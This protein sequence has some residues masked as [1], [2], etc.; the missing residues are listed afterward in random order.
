MISVSTPDPDRTDAANRGRAHPNA[1]PLPARRRA[2]T[3]VMAV[4]AAPVLTLWALVVAQWDPLVSLDREIATSLYA[5][6]RPLP[7][8][9]HLTEV[10]TETFGTWSMRVVSLLAACWLLLRRWISAA[11]WAAT[12]VFLANLFGLFLK[13][14]V[15]RSRPEFADP[16]GTGVGPS[17]PSGHALMAVVGTGIVLFATLPLLRGRARPLAW[18]VAVVIVL[19]TALSRPL[20][21]VHW[22]SDIVAGVSLG[23]FTLAGTLLLWS[24]LPPIARRWDRP[25]N[26]SAVRA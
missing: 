3:V 20:L 14:T 11:A 23:V 24:F 16:I 4:A 5:F 15:D 18:G 1:T 2:L 21:A 25:A 26:T 7:E 19:S 9:A 13:L 17:F 6:M 12:T 10:W 22:T 8:A